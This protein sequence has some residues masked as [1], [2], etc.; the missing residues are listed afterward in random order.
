MAA[1]A[2]QPDG[3]IT[4]AAAAAA[5]TAAAGFHWCFDLRGLNA[6][7]GLF[8]ELDPDCLGVIDATL[9]TDSL[10][11]IAQ[12]QARLLSVPRP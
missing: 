3:H 4:H 5:A 6:M 9:L 10:V 12:I 7:P 11:V 2:P 1:R 8:E